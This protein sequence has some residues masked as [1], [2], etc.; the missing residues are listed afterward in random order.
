MAIEPLNELTA[1]SIL[2]SNIFQEVFDEQDIIQRTRLLISLIDRAKELGVKTKFEKIAKAYEKANKQAAKD[3]QDIQAM[4]Y[5]TNFGEDKYDS[6]RCGGWIADQYGVRT[7][8]PFGGEI[9]ACYHPILPVQILVNAE[10]N[11]EKVKLAYKKRNVWKEIVVDKGMIASSNK[12]V[13]LSEY[14]IQVTSEN[15]KYLVKYL[16]E[17]ESMNEDRILEQI[18][19]SKMGW[20]R[21]EFIPYGSNILFD[22]ES[23]FKDAYESIHEE[24]NS[25]TWYGLANIVRH[26]KRFEP[27]IYLAAS[28]SS[29][30]IE[31]LNALPYIVNLWGDTGKGKTLAIMYAASV[32][33][34]PGGNDYITDP[35]STATALELRMDF[36]N[37]LPMLIDDMAQIKERYNGDFSELVY[38]LCSG[39]GKDRANASLGLNKPTS[40]KNCIITNG[41]HSLVTETMQGG[42]VNRIID[43]EMED[44]YIFENGNFVAEVLKNNYGFCGYDFINAINDIGIDSVKEI[45]KEFLQKIKDT[46]KERGIEKEEKQML[47]MSI[48]LTAD[49]IATDQLFKDGIY[50]DFNR[51][52]DLLKNRGDVSENDRAYEFIMSDVAININ[53]FVWDSAYLGEIWGAKDGEWLYIISSKFDDMCRRGNFSRKSFLSWANKRGL[54]KTS[55]GRNTK[56]KRIKGSMCKCICIKSMNEVPEYEQEELSDQLPFD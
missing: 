14:G 21:G 3:A 26:S 56:Q 19:T 32:W 16:S 38:M 18:S 34:Y 25:S 48:I 55:D 11:K 2:G 17:V 1:D 13:N 5:Y 29:V 6:L 27:Q 50:L 53:K 8:N 24:G 15:A 36:L 47:P 42:A 30:L 9:V 49:K 28:L 4:S 31:P 46:A 7:V 43:V 54:L 12:I 44:G 40:W 45:Q 20:I 22:N 39:K 41:E 10:T 35:K 51:C 23:R 37:N 52:V 33:A